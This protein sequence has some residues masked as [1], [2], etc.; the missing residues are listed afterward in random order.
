M[1]MIDY[2]LY[3]VFCVVAECGNITK[4]SE[5]LFISQPAVS[6][7]IK[8]LEDILGGTL[9]ERSKKGV[10]LTSEGKLIYEQIKHSINKLDSTIDYFDKLKKL[11]LGDLRIGSNTS[12]INIAIMKYIKEFKSKYPNI[13]ITFNWENADNIKKMLDYQLLD[14]ATVSYNKN[15]DY[16]DYDIIKEISINEY[17]VCSKELYDKYKDI[18]I[19]KNNIKEVPLVLL[20]KGYTTRNNF[21]IFLEKNN[22]NLNQVYEFD[23]YSL[24]LDFIKN[25]F[26]IGIVNKKYIEND[27]K[28]KDLYILKH[29]LNLEER[30]ILIITN[31]NHTS[32]VK[33]NFLNIINS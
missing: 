9:F 27:L 8:K 31:K 19:T 29:N 10:T 26:G 6:Y 20:T 23:S 11:D 17:F 12:N 16:S 32:I 1:D 5:K 2:N 30:K 14:I 21:E 7:S 3:K 33:E 18:T 22:I 24:A 4:A 25:G 15:D 28:N 13:N